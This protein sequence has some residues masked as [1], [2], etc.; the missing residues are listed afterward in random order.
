[1]PA[2]KE[3]SEENKRIARRVADA[4]GGKAEVVEYL[5]DTLPLV[6]HLL[7]SKDRPH[8]G[9]TSYSTLGLSDY[10]MLD[11]DKSE[12]PT[13][14]E[15]VGV[16][17]NK[18]RHYPNIIAGAAFCIMRTKRLCYP[19]AVMR[20][21]V[22]EYYPKTKLPHLYFTSPFLREDSL[23]TVRLKTKEVS[24][25]LVLPIA[26]SECRYLLRESDEALED[27]FE[28]EEI[29]IYDLSRKPVV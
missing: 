13:R 5:H 23:K 28:E 6:T 21:Y 9:V 1:M 27:R 11:D 3:P 25:L 15:I 2:K 18:V 29:D 22:K 26:E 14:L 24:W 16:S 7:Y 4:F 20:D 17:S 19:G 8:K 12:Y 10:P